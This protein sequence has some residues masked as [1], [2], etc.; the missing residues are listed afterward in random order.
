MGCPDCKHVFLCKIKKMFYGGWCPFCSGSGWYHCKD[1]DCEFCLDNSFASIDDAQFWDYDLNI[2]LTPYEV[3][4]MSSKEIWL[5]C[6]DCGHS[7][8]NVTLRI[9]RGAGCP[10][11]SYNNWSHC[12]DR[13]CEW[14]R[15]RSFAAHPKAIF[16][17]ETKNKD[18]EGM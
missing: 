11:C 3:P 12:G 17:H 9:T 5:Q 1:M 10:Y 18:A 8:K 2:K 13:D 4:T 14:C 7:Y 15:Q 16:W 6:M